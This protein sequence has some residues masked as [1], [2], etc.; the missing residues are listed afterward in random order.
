MNLDYKERLEN[1][2]IEENI[3]THGC[4]NEEWNCHLKAAF[5]NIVPLTVEASVWACDKV[6]HHWGMVPM[7]LFS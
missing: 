4:V 2:Q 6:D 7:F 1:P 5:F 3:L